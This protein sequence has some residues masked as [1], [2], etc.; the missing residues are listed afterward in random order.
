MAAKDPNL[1][2]IGQYGIGFNVVYHLTDCPSF[3]TNGNT[4]CVLD[5]HIRYVPGASERRPGRMYEKLD[6][7]VSGT[8][9]L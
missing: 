6:E 8:I 7:H 1:I 5:P 2:A 9:G 3:I 4:F